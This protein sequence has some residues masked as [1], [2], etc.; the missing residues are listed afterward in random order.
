[1]LAWL[2]TVIVGIGEIV[3]RVVIVVILCCRPNLDTD[4]YPVISWCVVQTFG[5]PRPRTRCRGSRLNRT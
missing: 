5:R 3:A 2:R 4:C 1:M